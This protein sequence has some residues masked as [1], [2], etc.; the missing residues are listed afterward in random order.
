MIAISASIG[1]LLL[2][3]NRHKKTLLLIFLGMV[4]GFAVSYFYSKGGN[5]ALSINS[6]DAPLVRMVKEGEDV[7]PINNNARSANAIA[8]FLPVSISG[9]NTFEHEAL[10]KE[11]D[12]V[13]F[14]EGL[15]NFETGQENSTEQYPWFIED[16][17]T[18]TSLGKVKVYYGNTAMNHTPHIAYVVKDNRVIFT[19]SGANIQVERSNPN[20]LETTETL[21]WNTGKY[22]R[23]K[24]DFNDDKFIPD[25][26]QISCRIE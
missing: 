9:G 20:G 24:Y 3:M 14:S 21:D 17:D 16:I 25:W 4:A 11:F 23:T 26:Y 12:S 19:A 2:N 1:R 18:F 10:G 15:Y 8:T 5:Q 6:T 7:C 13:K 22:K